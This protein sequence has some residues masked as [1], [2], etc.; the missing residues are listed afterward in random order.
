MVA[1]HGRQTPFNCHNCAKHAPPAS[2]FYHM[3]DGVRDDVGA[4]ASG[5]PVQGFADRRWRS[6]VLRS[7]I[8][9]HGE[10][11]WRMVVAR[12]ARG[13][14]RSWVLG[15]GMALTLGCGTKVNTSPIGSVID[16][17]QAPPASASDTQVLRL[18]DFARGH[19]DLEGTWLSDLQ[20]S[21]LSVDFEPGVGPPLPGSGT[22]CGAS[23]F[24][25]ATVHVKSRDGVVDGRP[26]LLRFEAPYAG[27][28]Q[29]TLP[30]IDD[31]HARPDPSRVFP[32]YDWPLT[33]VAP[34]DDA[35]PTLVVTLTDGRL[36]ADLVT[37]RTRVVGR[38]DTDTFLVPPRSDRAYVVPAE[39][40]E[41][42]APAAAYAALSTQ[43]T[44]FASAADALAS[45][46]GTWIRCRA[47]G[48]L[49]DA[50][51][52]IAPDGTWR[53]LIW[54]DGGLG[55][56]GG[57]Q[58]EG[59]LE[60]PI[61][62]HA[63][64]FNGAGFFQINLRGPGVWMPT[65]LWGD[66]LLVDSG[67]PLPDLNEQVSVY[68]RSAREV[69]AATNLPPSLERGGAPACAVPES[70]TSDP[71]LGD[72]DHV[73]R[74]E[75]TLCSGEMLEGFT[76]LRFDGSGQVT[77]MDGE[78]SAPAT[79]PY[80]TIRPNTIPV[81]TPR[82]TNLLFP[83]VNAAGAA[84]DWSIMLS[85]RPLKLWISVEGPYTL[86]RTSVFSALPAP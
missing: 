83:A 19:H 38:W 5:S 7:K 25:E 21:V 50:G 13:R 37:D 51:L 39:L 63:Q 33:P 40:V 22:E 80:R 18:L 32:S 77:L 86:R 60:D 58:R 36:A 27:I 14:G 84:D 45:I 3:S 67:T 55:A 17:C 76:T 46:H 70:G 30:D 24:V 31:A 26:T 35:N 85:E 6:C 28:L 79:R 12:F 53:S 4:I 10:R 62:T 69:I 59:F 56:R 61:D 64:G 23:L 29:V 82:E 44:P 43:Y 66:V 20:A 75:W 49:P 52:Q 74:G 42:C 78:G 81:L 11:G 65:H 72:L 57:F 71:E 9:G 41:E 73:L 54:R 47:A 1:W 2:I 16:S 34:V 48:G 68:V 8:A 15:A